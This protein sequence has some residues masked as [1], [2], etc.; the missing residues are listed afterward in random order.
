M[1]GDLP[2]HPPVPT[3]W[4]GKRQNGRIERLSKQTVVEGRSGGGRPTAKP[5]GDD[6]MK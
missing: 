4:L 3:Q 6:W 1:C 5:Q 2:S